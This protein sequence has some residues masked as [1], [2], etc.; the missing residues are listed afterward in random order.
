[1]LNPNLIPFTGDLMAVLERME[2]EGELQFEID[3]AD[4]F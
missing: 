1:M 2:A 4:I 3:P